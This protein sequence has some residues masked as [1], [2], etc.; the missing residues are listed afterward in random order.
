MNAPDRGSWVR[1]QIAQ[2]NWDV[3][4]AAE[5]SGVAETVIAAWLNQN[6]LDGVT[7]SEKF[8]AAV[9]VLAA[10]LNVASGLLSEREAPS[11]SFT[12][13]PVAIEHLETLVREMSHA[14]GELADTYRQPPT[15]RFQI[16]VRQGVTTEYPTD[17]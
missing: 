7:E 6:T 17:D 8:A 3:N 13:S 15:K 16:N 11:Q 9:E 2:R 5:A 12:P 14:V 4:D 1:D 10:T